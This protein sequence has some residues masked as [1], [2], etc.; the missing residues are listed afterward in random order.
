MPTVPPT[1][2][3][4][5]HSVVVLPGVADQIN[6]PGIPSGP[7]PDPD[8]DDVELVPVVTGDSLGAITSVSTRVHLSHR[9]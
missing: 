2:H 7:T 9:L 4:D 3:T 8:L 1:F 5:N 6:S